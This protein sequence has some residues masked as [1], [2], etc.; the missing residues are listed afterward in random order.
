[1]PEDKKKKKPSLGERMLLTGMAGAAR[2]RNDAVAYVE[3]V[4][5]ELDEGPYE[6]RERAA[7]ERER[8]RKKNNPLTKVLKK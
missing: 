6:A 2:V 7:K 1:V 5:K 4:K 3:G 8:E